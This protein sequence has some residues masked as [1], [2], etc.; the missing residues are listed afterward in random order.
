MN[1]GQLH[2]A[3]D[4][5]L[6]SEAVP[7]A[8]ELEDDGVELQSGRSYSPHT[9]GSKEKMGRLSTLLLRARDLRLL[10]TVDLSRL[11]KLLHLLRDKVE[12]ST[13]LCLTCQ[14]DVSWRPLQLLLY[15]LATPIPPS[16]HILH[17]HMGIV[18]ASKACSASHERV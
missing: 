18:H 11:C 14:D 8:G 13:G 16:Q 4:E 1:A 6:A 5:F 15:M 12:Q 9:Q 2:S 7:T 3:I 10:H 17:M